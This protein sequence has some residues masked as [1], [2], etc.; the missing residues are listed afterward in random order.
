[1]LRDVDN[2]MTVAQEEIFGPVTCVIP[3]EGLDDAVRIANDTKYGLNAAVFI[4]DAEQA[5]SVARRLR[6]G[7]V[8]INSVGVCLSEPFGGR[9]QS[10][11]GRECGAEGIL[12]FTDIQQVLLSGSYLDA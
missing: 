5:L 2:A 7:C 11:W 1:M 10:G 8:S 6:V 4:P 9:K 12:D 3:Y